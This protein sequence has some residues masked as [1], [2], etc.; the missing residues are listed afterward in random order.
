LPSL[1]L[2]L[3]IILVQVVAA[4]G[5]FLF[6]RLSN[7][8]GNISTLKITIALWGIVCFVAFMIDKTQDNIDIYFYALGGMLGLVLGALQS[9]SR[10][11]YSKLLPET[12][13][14][15][16]Y[17]S[18]YDVTEK[19]AIVFGTLVFGLLIALTGSMQW[20]V[21]SL[22]IFFLVAFIILS[23]IRKTKYVK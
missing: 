20:S 11:T 18:F 5:A 15:A 4:V 9:I 13:D 22:A 14:T 23:T 16:T 7:K 8:I 10:S 2:I 6:S 1:N 12:D 21:L 3:T 19:L 17:F